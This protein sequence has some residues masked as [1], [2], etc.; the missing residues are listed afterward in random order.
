MNRKDFI[1]KSFQLSILS[2]MLV[3][4]GFL[5]NRKQIDFSCSDNQSCKACSKYSKC[6]LDKALKS[7]KNEG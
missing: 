5:I 1:R 3:G 6:D 2:G 4:T 7:R